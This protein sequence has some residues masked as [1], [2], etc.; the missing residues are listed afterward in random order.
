MT[1]RPS[2]VQRSSTSKRTGP[3]IEA[4]PTSLISPSASIT[5]SCLITIGPNAIVQ[6]R[7]VICS[8]AGPID[9]GEG[10][11]I[12]E[13]AVIGRLGLEASQLEPFDKVSAGTQ[14]EQGV[15]IESGA[16]IEAISIGAF[17]TVEVGA[18]I[19][20]GAVIGTNCRI[21]SKVAIGDGEVLE[22]GVVV[23]GSLWGERRVEIGDGML[24]EKKRLLVGEQ[25]EVL[26]KAWTGK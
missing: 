24:A 14:L 3:P 1:T 19:G 23:F 20:K 16:I 17:T 25:G 11:I 8:A 26:R 5:G 2:P 18:S 21:C 10:C 7:S 12:S 4:H 13:R 9:I 22:D 15:V 6:I